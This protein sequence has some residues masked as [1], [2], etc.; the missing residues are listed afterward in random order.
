MRQRFILDENIL[1]YGQRE[2]NEADER[3]LTCALLITR[4]I[5]ICHT[6]VLDPLL[7]EKYLRQLNRPFH[8]NPESGSLFLRVLANA[9]QRGDKVD[10][11]TAA[12]AFPEEDTIPQGSQDDVPIVR[13]AV[14]SGAT[15]VTTDQAL[16]ED[17][18]SCGVQEKYSLR[19]M[20]PDQALSGL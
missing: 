6:L 13:L 14:E 12:R 7:R 20:L 19:V 16:V 18:N 9:F 3:D 1:I 5:D 10:F 11:R 15:L 2:T 17:L 4:I 8:Q